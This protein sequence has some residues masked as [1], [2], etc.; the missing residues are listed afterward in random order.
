MFTK[1]RYQAYNVLIFQLAIILLLAAIV[2]LFKDL[3]SGWSVLLGG[4]AYL[5]PS[6]FLITKFFSAKKHHTP[7]KVLTDFY[8]GELIKLGFSFILLILLFKFI[9]VKII[10]VLIGYGAAGL[11]LLFLPAVSRLI[12]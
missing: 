11:S 6:I 2:L 7:S 8:S 4:L 1:V 10:L 5:I 3:R 12:G 9:P